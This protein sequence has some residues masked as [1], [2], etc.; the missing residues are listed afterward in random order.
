VG[1]G[2]NAIV[3]VVIMLGTDDSKPIRALVALVALQA[4]RALRV[5]EPA[6][7]AE[8][9]AAAPA[10]ARR[11]LAFRGARVPLASLA[12]AVSDWALAAASALPGAAAAGGAV[13]AAG[14]LVNPQNNA[15]SSS[16]GVAAGRAGGAR[17][18]AP[19]F[20][21]LLLIG[22]RKRAVLHAGPRP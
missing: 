9:L 7:R 18:L 12:P 11:P 8:L 19:V 2:A 15:K 22:L 3:D 5:A 21:L 1:A 10:R 20:L 14:A 17:P 6:E 13:S 4:A 16:C